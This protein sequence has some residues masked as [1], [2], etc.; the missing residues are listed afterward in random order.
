MRCS[1]CP[2]Q[3]FVYVML[4]VMISPLASAQSVKDLFERAAQYFYDGKYDKAISDYEKIIELEPNFAPA[5]NALG[6]AMKVQGAKTD[7]VVYYFKKALELD[8]KFV[9]SYD[10]LGKLYY[11]EGDMD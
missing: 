6:L 8:N 3:I 7:D 4:F 11:S 2:T 10:N 5:Y 9:A 1:Y